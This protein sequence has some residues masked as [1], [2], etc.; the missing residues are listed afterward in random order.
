MISLRQWLRDHDFALQEPDVTDLAQCLDD[1][2]LAGQHSTEDFG[3]WVGPNC[4]VR[5]TSAGTRTDDVDRYVAHS[6]AVGGQERIEIADATPDE[7]GMSRE[8]LSDFCFGD[9]CDRI[10]LVDR[11]AV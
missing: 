4:V 10:V 3:L 6:W 2:G 7:D 9:G 1:E 11:D 5:N 8:E